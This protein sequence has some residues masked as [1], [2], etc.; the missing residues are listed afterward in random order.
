M[1]SFGDPQHQET[2]E[3]LDKTFTIIYFIG[4]DFGN[5]LGSPQEETARARSEGLFPD[6]QLIIEPNILFYFSI[7]KKKLYTISNKEQ[8]SDFDYVDS[9][10][11][12]VSIK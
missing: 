10:L 8:I 5:S 12:L 1:T 7:K 2:T 9:I 3:K 11:R 4:L 6:Q